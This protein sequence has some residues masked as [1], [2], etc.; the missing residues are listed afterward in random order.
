MHVGN[1]ALTSSHTPHGALS[2]SPAAPVAS[3]CGR[4]RAV[5]GVPLPA[6]SPFGGQ[7]RGQSAGEASAGARSSSSG[8]AQCGAD[9]DARKLDMSH[10]TH[11]PRHAVYT[12]G[13]ANSISDKLSQLSR[14]FS[15]GGLTLPCRMESNVPRIV[16]E[17]SITKCGACRRSLLLSGRRNAV[18]RRPAVSHCTL[19]PAL[20]A[21]PTANWSCRPVITVYPRHRCVRLLGILGSQDVDDSR[22][23]CLLQCSS[24]SEIW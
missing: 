11:T 14:G 7:V 4:A 19:R 17:I 15:A 5:P 2:T 16:A 3:T 24:R 22:I 18:G 8:S 13:P 9:V 23:N 6:P 10:T 21:A 1:R 20:F 12:R